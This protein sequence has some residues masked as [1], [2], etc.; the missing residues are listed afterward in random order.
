MLAYL[1]PGQGSQFIGMGGDLFQSPFY[2]PSLEQ[3]VDSVLGYSLRDVCLSGSEDQLRRTEYTQPCLFVVNALHYLKYSTDKR[4]AAYFAG[5]SLGEYNALH[6]TGAFD[7]VT[8]VRLVQQRGKLMAAA[9]TGAMAAVLGIDAERVE[10]GLK[11]YGLTRLDIANFNTPQQVVISGPE[12]DIQQAEA[13]MKSAGARRYIVLQVSAAF[14]SRYMEGVAKEFAEYIRGIE[15][16]KLNTTVISNVTARPY[17]M[18]GGESTRALLVQQ[19]KSQ[20]LWSPSIGYMKAKGVT[21]FIEAG[22]GITLSNMLQ[23]IPA[24][25]ADGEKKNVES[26]QNSQQN[27]TPQ[28]RAGSTESEG[29]IEQPEK[30]CEPLPVDALSSFAITPEALGSDSFKSDYGVKYAYVAGAMFKGI[31]SKELVA[32][33][34]KEGLLSYLGTGGMRL[35]EIEEAIRYIKDAV[36]NGPYGMNLLYQPNDLEAEERAVDCYLQH[37]VQNVEAAGYMTLSPAIVR[38]RLSGLG[39]GIDG[40]CSRR[41]RILA[42]VSRPEVASMFMHPAPEHIVKRLVDAGKITRE[43]AELARTVPMADDICVEADSGGHTDGGVAITLF[44]A[45]CLLRD[46]IVREYTNPPCIRVGAA[47]GIGTPHSAAAAFIMGADFI[48]TGSINQCTVEAGTSDSVKDLLEKI[49]AQDT[50]YAPAGDMFEYGA[51]IQVV[52]KGLFFHVRANMLYD[53]Y[54]RYASLEEIPE[55]IINKIENKFF[56]KKLSEVWEETKAHYHRSE[57][58]DMSEVEQN[59]KMKMALIFKWYFIHSNRL[60]LDGREEQKVDYQ[61]QCG[62]ALGAFNRWVKG[63]SFESWHNRRVAGIAGLLM[64]GTAELLTERVK[65]Y[66]KNTPQNCCRKESQS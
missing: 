5:H 46:E 14:H 64:K 9:P 23:S 18:E 44:P 37:G 52:R 60:A 63:T 45:I 30:A 3:Q 24:L 43:Q 53:L 54:T 17:P 48:L 1:F 35:N 62:P 21:E 10:A 33:M 57:R 55:E 66:L 20:V 32:A 34:C 16:K 15:F 61:I 47:G 22:P 56:K 19:I 36:P 38:F 13:A 39:V 6:A 59:P 29:R 40:S 8:G 65:S 2:P 51:K 58:V 28:P 25:V 27:A 11:E 50:A 26:E 42:K 41:H 4:K 7:I 49:E 12:A 31:A